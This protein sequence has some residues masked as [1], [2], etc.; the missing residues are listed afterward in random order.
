MYVLYFYCIIIITIIFSVPSELNYTKIQSF[1]RINLFYLENL[2]LT[3]MTE[4]IGQFV[5]NNI[6]CVFCC[7]AVFSQLLH[8]VQCSCM[9]ASVTPCTTDRV[10]VFQLLVYLNRW[11]ITDFGEH[12]SLLSKEGNSTVFADSL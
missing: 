6:S 7:P 12:I 2:F 3:E 8:Q 5:Y 9:M 10:T 1:L 11:S 4:V